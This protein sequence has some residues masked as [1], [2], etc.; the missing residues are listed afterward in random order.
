M[1][2]SDVDGRIEGTLGQHIAELNAAGQLKLGDERKITNLA[3]DRL[4]FQFTHPG[5]VKT[6][7]DIGYAFTI[8]NPFSAVTQIGDLGFSSFFNGYYNTFSPA[9]KWK[10]T[11]D[12]VH[13]ENPS[14]EFDR[15]GSG[16]DILS[17]LYTIS[18]FAKMDGFGKTKLMSGYV[19][20]MAK[21]TPEQFAEAIHGYAR[22]LQN[23]NTAEVHRDFVDGN[24]TDDVKF[25]A[26]A[27]L[28][29]FQPVS[30]TEMP[31]GY[32]NHPGARVFYMLKS[33]TIRQLDV[34]RR[35]GINKIRKGVA[36]QD[37]ALVA[38]GFTA[39]GHLAFAMTMA[40]AT[41]D[42]IKQMMA[43]QSVD[44]SENLKNNLL[45]IMAMSRY[46]TD[47]MVEFRN[48][49][50]GDMVGDLLFSPPIIDLVSSGYDTMG[51]IASGKKEVHK[52]LLESRLIA[53]FPVVG[54]FIYHHAGLGKARNEA[55]LMQDFVDST[56]GETEQAAR[57]RRTELE[58]I[59]KKERTPEQ[60]EELKHITR[61]EGQG[62][63]GLRRRYER[64]MEE[65]IKKNDYNTVED[66]A[67]MITRLYAD[68]QF[69]A[70]EMSRV[71]KEG[72]E[73]LPEERLGFFGEMGND[74]Y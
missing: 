16:R 28:S 6:A 65:A 62:L 58:A 67:R 70:D 41:A 24:I 35:E 9:G 40:G 34:F 30:M 8:A 38:A 7:T 12:M 48:G 26:F 21:L 52:A 55:S 18:G 32:I 3:R 60:T 29:D 54:K 57:A 73:Y 4:N 53:Q 25:L 27:A 22:H 39:L 14:V 50:L 42:E 11:R 49:A 19:K 59:P 68:P 15:A 69:S 10:V 1:V 66:A 47:R 61:M 36:N 51:A 63:G 23:P 37:G 46:H 2:A 20:R 74:E 56:Y 5:L 44:F 31:R 71:R 45:K 43:G 13:L 17:K 33:F 72:D 64:L